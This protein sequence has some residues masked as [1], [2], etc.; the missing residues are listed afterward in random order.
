M[1]S[2]F[3]LVPLVVAAGCG[4]IL[5]DSTDGGGVDGGPLPQTCNSSADCPSGGDCAYPDTGGC[6][7]HKQCFPPK[8]QCKGQL[9]CACD[10][11]ST[12]D[13]CNGAASKPIAHL[14]V[15]DQPP[16]CNT[17]PACELCDISAFSPATLAS[18]ETA[19]QACSSSDIQAFVTACVSATATQATCE[20]WQQTDA[21]ASC[22]ACIFASSTAAKS[23]PL[24][25]DSTGCATN[26]G[27]CVDIVLGEV[28]QELGSGGSGS[29]GDLV[30][31]EYGC[32]DYACS[33]CIS[34]PDFDTCDTDAQKMEC[35]TYADAAMNSPKCATDVDTSVCLPQNDQG[36][37][38][39]I[40]VFCG[41][42]P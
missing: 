37:A 17:E 28:S 16:E 20:A 39:F 12:A 33:S 3:F 21:G 42:G 10:G 30:N 38:S 11:T 27:G 15:C 29:C 40:G 2:T 25:C 41:T 26:T 13:D 34:T 14:G 32:I 5:T 23:G 31:A 35:K 24:I 22:G 18:P 4:G 9:V 8:K 6:A 7:A 1:R 19:T 36:W